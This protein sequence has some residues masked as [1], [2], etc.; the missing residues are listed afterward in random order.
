MPG[1]HRG[2]KGRRRGRETHSSTS[3]YPLVFVYYFLLVVLQYAYVLPYHSLGA[4]PVRRAR[5]EW[6]SGATQGLPAWWPDGQSSWSGL[7]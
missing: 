1:G 2:Y 5:A 6:A 7:G 4:H 3:V